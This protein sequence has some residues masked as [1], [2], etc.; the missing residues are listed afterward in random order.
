VDPQQR[1]AVLAE[2]AELL[3]SDD[4]RAERVLEVHGPLLSA[5][6]GPGFRALQ[7]AVGQFDFEK[8][9]EVLASAVST[10][11]EQP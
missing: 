3:G 4:P 6:L 5:V 1:T 11:E 10:Q 7:E 2:L 9:L 8:A